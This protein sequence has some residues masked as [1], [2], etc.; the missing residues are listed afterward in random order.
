MITAEQ[1]SIVGGHLLATID[2]M[3]SPGQEVL[4]AWGEAYGVLANVFIQ[5]EE[6]IYQEND[7]QEGGWRGLREFELIAKE[8][9]SELITSFTFTPTDDRPVSH[10]KPGQYLGIYLTSEEFEN[11]EIRQYSL[12][13]A[14][15]EKNI[16]YISKTRRWR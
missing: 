15:Q 8:K 13:S 1:Y 2:E 6:Q 12:S 10:F 11:Q 4:D 5:R 3:L 7:N 9:E 14:P 16:P